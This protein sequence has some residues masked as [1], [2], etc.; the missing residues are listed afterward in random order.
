MRH[1]PKYMPTQ[2]NYTKMQS[3]WNDIIAYGLT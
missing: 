1:I 2:K 3:M